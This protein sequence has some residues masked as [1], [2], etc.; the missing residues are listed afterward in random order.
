MGKGGASGDAKVSLT[1]GPAGLFRLFG[2]PHWGLR[3]CRCLRRGSWCL[4][5]SL[6]MSRR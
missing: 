1:H 3:C 4:A 2:L 6:G 5:R